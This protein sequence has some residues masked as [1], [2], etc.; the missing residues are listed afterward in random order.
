M[1]DA[2]ERLPPAA[3]RSVTPSCEADH[4][5]EAGEQIGRREDSASRGG[6][7]LSSGEARTRLHGGL[8]QAGLSYGPAPAIVKEKNPRPALS[9]ASCPCPSP[10]S[11]TAPP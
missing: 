5:A 7:A 3:N 8:L 10:S 1:R 11:G 4:S 6:E 9:P 2:E